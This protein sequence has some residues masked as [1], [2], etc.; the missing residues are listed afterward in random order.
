MC[1]HLKRPR[2]SSAAGGARGATKLGKS[3][4]PAGLLQRLVSRAGRWHV[5]ER[6]VPVI[7]DHRPRAIVRQ[8]RV[9]PQATG[10][11]RRAVGGEA[12]QSQDV[13]VGI[14]PLAPHEDE[15]RGV[16]LTR[17]KKRLG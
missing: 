16:K 2:Q 15:V 7:R 11:L 1:Y 12:E 8:N 14:P 6:V 17:D 3:A 9:T 5:P 4:C 13:R 10:R